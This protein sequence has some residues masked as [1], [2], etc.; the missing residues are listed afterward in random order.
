MPLRDEFVTYCQ[1][2]DLKNFIINKISYERR[3][4]ESV[5]EKSLS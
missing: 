4:Y 1:N 2:F 3:G 5:N